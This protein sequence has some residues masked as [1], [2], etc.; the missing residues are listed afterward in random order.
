MVKT[1]NVVAVVVLYNPNRLVIKN[2]LTYHSFLENI[3]VVDNSET[4][5]EEI[6]NDLKK[7]LKTHLI[8][9]HENRGI[10]TALNQGIEKA[11]LL[12]GEWILTMDQDSYFEADMLKNYFKLFNDLNDKVK[13]A[14]LG[15]SYEKENSL[16]QII[17]VENLITSGTLLNADVFK[18][19]KGYDEKLFIDEVDNDY[20]Y[21]AQL[22]GYDL[23][24][25]NNIFMNHALGN[26][27]QITSIFGS[28]KTR[29][30]H[31][32]I[33]LYYIVRNSLYMSE[34]YKNVFPIAI[35]KTNRDVIV[36][37]KN[38]LL[39]GS[40]KWSTIKFLVLGILHFKKNRFG[41]Y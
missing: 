41:K 11:I 3:V 35:K 23:Y 31:S 37:I 38:N 34:K 27:K 20:C 29:I 39:Y 14:A 2:I 5:N 33:R 6:L 32:P 12:G 21:R 19:I 17:K 22:E 25:C 1:K 7:M 18:K 15:P 30:L 8:V 4:A 16:E 28:K 24:Q 26:K 40:E 10:A 36:R 9:N 13:I